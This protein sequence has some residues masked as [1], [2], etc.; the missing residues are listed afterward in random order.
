[1]TES[2]LE[3]QLKLEA[4]MVSLG[5][6]RYTASQETDNGSKETG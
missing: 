1:M 6:S 4:E 5:V 2:L 3:Q